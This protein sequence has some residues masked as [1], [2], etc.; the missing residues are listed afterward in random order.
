MFDNIKDSIIFHAQ[1]LDRFTSPFYIAITGLLLAIIGEFTFKKI[2][3]G[4]YKSKLLG[5]LIEKNIDAWIMAGI[6]IPIIISLAFFW[7][8]WEKHQSNI[9]RFMR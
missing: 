6:L 3:S 9:K 5:P 7:L 2:E 4:F 8:A 1:V